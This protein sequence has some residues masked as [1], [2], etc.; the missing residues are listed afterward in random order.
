M[1]ATFTTAPRDL[2]AIA[3]DVVCDIL[4]IFGDPQ[5]I[6]RQL[7]LAAKARAQMLAW[8]RA[9]EAVLRHLLL[10]EAAALI[11]TL[12]PLPLRGDTHACP[13]A[14][15]SHSVALDACVSPRKPRSDEA[16]ETWRIA[17]RAIPPRASCTT[18]RV[19]YA[20][21]RAPADPCADDFKDPQTTAEIRAAKAAW[22]AE[23]NAHSVCSPACGGAVAPRATEGE[24]DA[25]TQSCAAP[26]VGCAATSP[27]CGGGNL[28]YPSY[29]LARRVEALLRAYNTP[30]PHARRLA[31]RLRRTA[32][33]ARRLLRIP[34]DIDRALDRGS[35]TLIHNTT[36]AHRLAPDSS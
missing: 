13:D 2:W 9:G 19:A 12:P 15:Q 21:T 29:P 32:N 8:L 22:L 6:A 31:F 28:L 24:S 5:D 27:A 18:R 7:G 23:M 17:F 1:S 33:L 14:S 16:P 26:S 30:A 34:R 20:Y 36:L 3:R 10:I 11:P 4:N 35:V 25:C